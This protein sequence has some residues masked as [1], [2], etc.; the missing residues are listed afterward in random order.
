MKKFK[1]VIIKPDVFGNLFTSNDAYLKNFLKSLHIDVRDN[2]QV[3]ELIL[4]KKAKK[5]TIDQNSR[6]HFLFSEIAKDTGNTTTDVKE[7]YKKVF[8]ADLLLDKDIKKKVVLGITIDA[9]PISTASLDTSEFSKYCELIE[10]H[11]RDFLNI[12]INWRD[13]GY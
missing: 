4:K 12:T 2:R 3:W 10:Q 5:R 8:L 6:L 7:A 11:A 9:R 13:L 1:P